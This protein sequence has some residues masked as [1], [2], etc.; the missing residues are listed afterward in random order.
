MNGVKE[1][2]EEPVKV[3][4]HLQGGLVS[5]EANKFHSLVPFLELHL[6]FWEEK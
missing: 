1:E 2:E 3:I 5:D 6:F 4:M